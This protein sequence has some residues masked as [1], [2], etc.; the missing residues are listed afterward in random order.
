MVFDFLVSLTFLGHRNPFLFQE[1]DCLTEEA[2]D[3]LFPDLKEPTFDVTKKTGFSLLDANRKMEMEQNKKIKEDTDIDQAGQ[4][5]IS[6]TS[7]PSSFSERN[8]LAKEEDDGAG[9]LEKFLS[10][11]P[12]ARRRLINGN[13]VVRLPDGSPAPGQSFFVS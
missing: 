6:L 9:D 7:Q 13:A 11:T 2:I 12:G 5:N 4:L 10:S 3:Q 1:P 8:L